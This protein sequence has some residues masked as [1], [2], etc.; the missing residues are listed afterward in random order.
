MKVKE[1]VDDYIKYSL[2]EWLYKLLNSQYNENDLIKIL[3]VFHSV[4]RVYYRLNKTK[5]SYKDFTN[6]TPINEDIFVSKDNLIDTKEYKDG[7]FYVQ[8]YNSASLYSH[9]D[10]K[11]SM[12]LLDVCSAPGSKLFNC[13][14]ILKPENCY[15]NDIYEHRVNLIKKAADRLGFKGINYSCV[16]GLQLY[17]EFPFKFDRIMLDVPCSGL[18]VISRKPDLKYHITPNSLDELQELQYNL[19]QANS[20]L[21]KKDGILL[22]ST[23]TLN[24]KENSKNIAKFV[25][26]ND[27]FVV[28]EEDTIINE[29]GDCFYYAKLKKVLWFQF[30]I[31][32]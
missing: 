11:P 24:K 20:K 21:L 15:S 23:C 16:D 1:Y 27:D 8:D 30:T 17:K 19:L 28:L 13:L 10:L 31:Y 9:L 32:L 12:N 26:S 25:S 5:A 7:L 29:Y 18:G 2:P 3:K 22:Y 4:P 14:D 6:I